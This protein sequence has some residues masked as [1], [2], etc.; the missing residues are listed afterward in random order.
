[1]GEALAA[2]STGESVI[3]GGCVIVEGGVP[4]LF[5]VREEATAVGITQSAQPDNFPGRKW[6]KI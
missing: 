4:G 1:M 5:A 2:A 6:V 3:G